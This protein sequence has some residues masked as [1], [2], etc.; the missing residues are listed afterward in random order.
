MRMA[1]FNP[2]AYR[3][4]GM[5]RLWKAARA[6]RTRQRQ[7]ADL[8]MEFG[9]VEAARLLDMDEVDLIYLVVAASEA[10]DG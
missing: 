5:V 3:P 10:D 7:A 1:S 9:G 8:W 4:R 2:F 6:G